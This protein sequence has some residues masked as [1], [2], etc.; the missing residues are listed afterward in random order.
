MPEVAES[1]TDANGLF[2]SI[3]LAS[4]FKPRRTTR[5]KPSATPLHSIFLGYHFQHLVEFAVVDSKP[6]YG[7]TVASDH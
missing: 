1:T 6:S 4:Q 5:K 2:N 3:Q 7:E